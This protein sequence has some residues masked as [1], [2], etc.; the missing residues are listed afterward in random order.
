MPTSVPETEAGR[1]VTTAALELDGV[2][3]RYGKR[4]AVTDAALTVLPGEAVAVLGHNGAGKSS[5][6]RA[7]IGIA[8][9]TG[10]RVVVNGTDLSGASSAQRVKAGLAFSPQEHYAFADLTVDQNLGLGRFTVDDDETARRRLEMV[11]RLF[12]LLEERAGSLARRM[13]GGQQRMLGIGIALMSSPKV[14]LLD[15]PSLGLAPA[16]YQEI[17]RVLRRLVDEEGVSLLLVEQNVKAALSI[18][19]R[20][21]VVQG[22]RVVLEEES[23]QLAGRDDLWRFF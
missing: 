7:A 19:D 22:G 1:V 17:V 6:L 15:E 21:Y 14:L 2:S 3:V 18:T 23:R 9:T 20:A 5:L 11:H 10:G 8:P 12:P 13:S 4:E 16:L